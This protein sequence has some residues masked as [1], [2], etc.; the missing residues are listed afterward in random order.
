MNTWAN[1]PLRKAALV[2][3]AIAA[4]TLFYLENPW[5]NPTGD[6][7]ALVTWI[8]WIASIGL[9]VSLVLRAQG[10]ARG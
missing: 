2:L 9:V 1:S 4:V 6:L 3:G 10:R 7:R 5:A 8:F